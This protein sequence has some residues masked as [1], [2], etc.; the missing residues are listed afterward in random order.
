MSCA[1][2]SVPRVSGRRVPESI[3]QLCP[4]A[5]G[6]VPNRLSNVRFSLM[7]NTTCLIGQRVLK[8]SAMASVEEPGES[9]GAGDALG[10]A[11]PVGGGD[12]GGPPSGLAVH[13]IANRTATSTDAVA[14]RNVNTGKRRG[15]IGYARQSKPGSRTPN[16]CRRR[17]H[18]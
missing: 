2:W 1:R 5:P 8:L 11:G 7:R 12:G 15:V 9:S 6:N 14:E 13:A 3:P 17:A 10:E 18:N 4:F 16:E